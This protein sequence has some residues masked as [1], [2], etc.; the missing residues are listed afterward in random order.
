ME[1]GGFVRRHALSAADRSH[2]FI[3]ER[4]N[5]VMWNLDRNRPDNTDGEEGEEENP[6]DDEIERGP[7]VGMDRL[8]NAMRIDQNVA[9]ARE[10]WDDASQIQTAIIHVLNAS[11]GPNPI[12]LTMDVITQVRNVFQRLWRRSRSRNQNERADAYRRYIDDI[13][14]VMNS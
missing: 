14:G 12:G 4:G 1:F 11:A 7:T 2:M 13:H 6:T 10:L 9:L 5:F 3:Q 8:V